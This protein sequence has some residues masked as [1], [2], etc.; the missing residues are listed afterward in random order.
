MA[1]PNAKPLLY[2]ATAENWKD[3]AELA[4]MYK[5]PT[6]GFRTKTT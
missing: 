3:T 1:A 2:A 5:L 6:S 4:L